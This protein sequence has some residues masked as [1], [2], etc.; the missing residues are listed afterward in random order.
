MS[1]YALAAGSE[2]EVL[3][4]YDR[5]TNSAL[6][7][8]GNEFDNVIYGNNGANTLTGGGGTDT[9]YGLGGN[10]SFIV[11]SPGDVVVEFAG[12]GNDTVY[13]S[14]DYALGAGSEVEVLTVYDRAT[15]SALRLTGNEFS[16]ILYGN[17]GANVLDGGTGGADTLYGLG[18]NDAFIVHNPDDAVVEFAGQGYDTVYATSDFALS[19]SSEVEVLTVYDRAT[20]NAVRLTGNELS[21]VIYGNNGA[22]VLDGAAGAGDTLYG[23]GGN[24]AFIVHNPG[25]AVVEFAGQGYDTVYATS[26]YA[27]TAGSEIEVITVYDRDTTNALRLT[28]NEFGNTI[29]G[30]AGANVLDGGGG[31]DTLYGMGG[32]DSYI[33]D[34]LDSVIESAGGGFDTVYA[35]GSFTLTAGSEIETLTVYDRAT[36]NALN[37]VGNEFANTIYGNAGANVIDGKAGAD[38]IYLM[39]GTDTVLF[40]TSLGGG[41]VDAVIGFTSGDDRIQLVSATFAGLPTGAL[42]SGAFFA[43]TAAHDADDR[44]IYDQATGQLYFDADGNGSGAAVLFATFSPGTNLSAGD[45]QII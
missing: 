25:D 42:A 24:D 23:L 1:D 6:R 39:G 11:D 21:N 2:I 27:L 7:L 43:G 3:T 12:Q 30:N 29:Y 16:N 20:T 34:N 38:T 28:G 4:V 17:N 45:F 22:N 36:T 32:N 13:A 15:T 35:F 33:V 18:G 9:F 19:A 41:N 26:D 37:L 5:D 8:T 14:S 40:S 31:S 44:I 10:D